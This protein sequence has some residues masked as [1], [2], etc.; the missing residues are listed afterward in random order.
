M[1]Q[2]R[3]VLLSALFLAALS[4][5]LASKDVKKLQIGVKVMSGSSKPSLACSLLVHGSLLMMC[6]MCAAQAQGVR[7][8]GQDWRQAFHPLH[9]EHA[10]PHCC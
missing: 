7:A 3:I 4:L 8:E 5:S 2:F 6:L 1:A 9:G 10:S